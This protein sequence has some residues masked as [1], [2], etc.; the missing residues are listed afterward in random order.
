MLKLLNPSSP[1]STWLSAFWTD[2]RRRLVN[3]LGY[4]LSSISPSL[5][6]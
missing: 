4:S 1:S 5:A 2:F 3:L 6:L